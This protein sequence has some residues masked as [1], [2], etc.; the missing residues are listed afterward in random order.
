MR[1]RVKE[2]ISYF[3]EHVNEYMKSLIA[4]VEYRDIY[5]V[6][7]QLLDEKG[8]ENITGGRGIPAEE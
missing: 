1:D 4:M 7:E 8:R 2:Q 3:Y 6:Y 5:G